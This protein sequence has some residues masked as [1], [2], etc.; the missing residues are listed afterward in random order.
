M[1]LLSG[2]AMRSLAN[3]IFALLT[4]VLLWAGTPA[5][6]M[7]VAGCIEASV[8][9]ASHFEGDSD[10]VPADPDKGTPHHHGGCHGHHVATSSDDDGTAY[11]ADLSNNV[12]L[13]LAAFTA[14]CDPGTALRPPIA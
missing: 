5:R 1:F 12:G 11:A 9:A 3:F 13:S 2:R 4:A 10:Q 6:A 8:D 7:D 14:G